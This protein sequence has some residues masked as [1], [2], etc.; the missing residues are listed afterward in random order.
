MSSVAP[1]CRLV[2][3]VRPD[4]IGASNSVF[5][6]TITD[7]FATDKTVHSHYPYTRARMSDKESIRLIR[8]NL[9]NGTIWNLLGLLSGDQTSPI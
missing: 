8:R 5:H 2:Y 3:W 9:L 7:G 1:A 6:H 4:L